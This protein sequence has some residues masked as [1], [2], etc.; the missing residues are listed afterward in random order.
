[1]STDL[2]ALSGLRELASLWPLLDDAAVTMTTRGNGHPVI[3]AQRSPVRISILDV[4]RDVAD[5][6]T[7][8]S[9]LV[10]LLDQEAIGGIPESE[11]SG[12]VSVI[13]HVIRIRQKQSSWAELAPAADAIVAPVMTRLLYL[14]GEAGIYRCPQC[15]QIVTFDGVE[16]LICPVC[17]V[18]VKPRYVTYEQASESLG[19]SRGSLRLAVHRARLVPLAGSYPPRYKFDELSTLCRRSRPRQAWR[20]LRGPS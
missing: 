6:L 14:L 2:D 17:G 20:G 19:V 5:A 8:L 13:L 4:K 7:Q 11:V 9:H 16:R 3:A 15:G 18:K 10:G 12:A 1:V